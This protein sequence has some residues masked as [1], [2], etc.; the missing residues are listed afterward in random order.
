MYAA[1]SVTSNKPIPRL[2]PGKLLERIAA[3]YAAEDEI[4]GRPPDVR[5]QVR[6]TRA[7]PLLQSLVKGR[8]LRPH[9]RIGLGWPETTMTNAGTLP[10]WS[11]IRSSSVFRCYG[12]VADTWL[13]ATL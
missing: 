12:T 5:Q 4:R 6:Q 13:E 11:G 10:G 8:I 1:S 3:L 9:Q 7:R 2:W